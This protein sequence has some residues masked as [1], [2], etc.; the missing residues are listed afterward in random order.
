MYQGFVK[1]IIIILA[2]YQ[3][4]EYHIIISGDSSMKKEK[5]ENFNCAEIL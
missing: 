4:G 2:R 1:I 5:I 3:K